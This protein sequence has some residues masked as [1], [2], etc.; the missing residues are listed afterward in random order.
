MVEAG[1]VADTATLFVFVLRCSATAG[2]EDA[3]FPE[4]R[5]GFHREGV[6]RPG[7]AG[8]RRNAVLLAAGVDR[9]NLLRDF[10][11]V[12]L[13]QSQMVAGV[14]ADFKAVL[15]KLGDFLPGHVVLLVVLEIE[16]LGDEERRAELV[17]QQHW[18]GDREVRPR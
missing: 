2:E 11:H 3:F 17:L 6:S 12:L 16:S 1:L 7:E 9:L 18:A 13:R 5:E 8:G 4:R 14:I 10:R 15:M